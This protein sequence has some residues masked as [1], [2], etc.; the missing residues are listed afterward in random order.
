MRSI[1]GRLGAVGTVLALGL[2]GSTIAGVA[3]EPTA[4]DLVDALNGLFGKC[5][6]SRCSHQRHLSNRKIRP[7]GGG[8]QAV[9]GSAFRQGS[10][11]PGAFLAR[12]R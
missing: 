5:R 10:A 8:A 6:R 2:F 7:L 9:E 1:T 11:H 12:R 4:T 3:Q